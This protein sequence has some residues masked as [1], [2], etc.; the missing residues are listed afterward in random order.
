MGS[1]SPQRAHGSFFG[2]FTPPETLGGFMSTFNGFKGK[3]SQAQRRKA[4]ECLGFVVEMGVSWRLCWSLMRK[5]E[6]NMV[7]FSMLKLRG[8]WATRWGLWEST[9]SVSFFLFIHVQWSNGQCG[10]RVAIRTS[11]CFCL[12]VS[13]VKQLAFH[14][15]SNKERSHCK[16]EG[17]DVDLNSSVIFN[18]HWSFAKN[19][20]TTA[21]SIG[22]G[23][24]DLW[25]CW[26]R[27]K[28]VFFL[29]G[30]KNQLGPFEK[31]WF[32]WMCFCCRDPS[33][34]ISFEIPWFLGLGFWKK[35]PIRLFW[36]SAWWL[37]KICFFCSICFLWWI[38]CMDRVFY[39]ATWSHRDFEKLFQVESHSKET[40]HRDISVPQQKGGSKVRNGT[41][42]LNFTV[43]RVFL[44]SDSCP[45]PLL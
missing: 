45:I 19:W 3:H 10:A 36:G 22:M 2:R 4:V 37:W 27:E 1:A 29:S 42:F 24:M 33:K 5:L 41:V 34:T 15:F 39:Y 30:P 11:G 43:Y 35:T 38:F 17:H 28:H 13:Q 25:G 26:E 31:E 40:K 32:V 7:P 12:L 8:K 9:S 16:K 21:R 44:F 18:E 14:S 6:K 23:S 20:G